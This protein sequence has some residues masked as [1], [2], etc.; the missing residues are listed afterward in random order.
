MC[1]SN[2]WEGAKKLHR[3][4][5]ALK[6]WHV[7]RTGSVEG[8]RTRWQRWQSPVPKRSARWTCRDAA[9]PGRTVRSSRLAPLVRQLDAAGDG[10]RSSSTGS[11]PNF[12]VHTRRWANGVALAQSSP[13]LL[14]RTAFDPQLHTWQSMDGEAPRIALCRLLSQPD[15]PPAGASSAL[16]RCKHWTISVSPNHHR[17]TRQVDCSSTNPKTFELSG[18]SRKCHQH[19]TQVTVKCSIL[20][21]INCDQSSSLFRH[22]DHTDKDDREMRCDFGPFRL[23]HSPTSRPV[24]HL[25]PL[26]TPTSTRTHGKN[27][28]PSTRNSPGEQLPL[29]NVQENLHKCVLRAQSNFTRT[30]Q[31]HLSRNVPTALQPPPLQRHINL[32][33]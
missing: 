14:R 11:A 17:Q 33:C 3:R 1:W 31:S 30:R 18:K 21:R 25:L 12:A 20:S 22:R 27:A 2:C 8:Y 9:W 19:S 16:D 5:R 29:R 24:L 32:P 23:F 13:P 7:A 4:E 28:N 10:R 15:T 26:T 6:I